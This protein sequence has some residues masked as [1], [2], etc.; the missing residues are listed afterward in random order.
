MTDVLRSNSSTRSTALMTDHYELTMLQAALAEGTAGRN[1]TFEAFTRRLP[2]GRRYG[3]VAGIGRVVEAL[4]N[5]TFGDAQ[6][7]RLEP[8]L[9][10]PTIKYLAEYRFDGD[11]DAYPE[12]E[13][14]FPGSPI[15]T[16]RGSFGSA[17]ILETLLL[18]ILNHDCAIA[19]AA[20]RMV[21]LANGRNLIEMCS[22]RTH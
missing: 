22:R 16:V 11:I 4:E 15:L 14:F 21:S 17:G 3:V 6:L 9:D 18:S 8:I 1:C 20:A 12:G 19:S 13:L 10:A 7:A 2:E 5:F